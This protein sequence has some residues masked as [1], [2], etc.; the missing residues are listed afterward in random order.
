MKPT[1]TKFGKIDEFT[2]VDDFK[3]LNY[4]FYLNI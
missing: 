1:V 4:I 2:M 3:L